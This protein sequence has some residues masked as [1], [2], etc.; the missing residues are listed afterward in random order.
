[1]DLSTTYMGLKLA[2]PLVP[3]ASPLSYTLD[4]IRRLEDAGA[5][6][7][8]VHSLFEEQIEGESH[9]LDHYMSYGTD[10]FAEAL[11]YFPQM[12]RYNVGPASYLNLI[13]DAKAA[14]QIPIIA[15]L[16]GVSPGGWIEYAQLIEQA[17]ADGLELNIYYIPVDPA[18]NSATV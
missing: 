11:D 5:A 9:I 13:S 6:A 1:M 8:V 12:Q 15:S 14:T 16:N 4:G 3:S 18:L 2:H 10:S 17:G 7:V